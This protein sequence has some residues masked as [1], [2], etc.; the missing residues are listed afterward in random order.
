MYPPFS[1]TYGD[2]QTGEKETHVISH[3][4]QTNTRGQRRVAFTVGVQTARRLR[5]PV[6]LRVARQEAGPVHQVTSVAAVLQHRAHGQ[7]VALGV[8]QVSGAVLHRGG[9]DTSLK[10]RTFQKAATMN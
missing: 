6:S 9:S 8:R 7:R 3:D 4:R 5:G 1:G 2:W 10:E